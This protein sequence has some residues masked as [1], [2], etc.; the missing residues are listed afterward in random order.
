MFGGNR[1]ENRAERNASESEV[2]IVAFRNHRWGGADQTTSKG[3]EPNERCLALRVIERPHERA[4]AEKRSNDEARGE[5]AT[6]HVLVDVG[7]DDRRTDHA[8]RQQTGEWQEP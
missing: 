6:R 8:E 3:P 4:V 7:V 5:Q 1:S 2:R